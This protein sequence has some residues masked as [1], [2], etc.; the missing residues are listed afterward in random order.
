MV[1]L[2]AH[3]GLALGVVWFE[4]VVYRNATNKDT[5]FMDF[6]KSFGVCQ[7]VANL[8]LF[9]LCKYGYSSTYYY[10]VLI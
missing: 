6:C 2:I 7:T 8:V 3:N 1:W 5:M 9:F 4:T 10:F